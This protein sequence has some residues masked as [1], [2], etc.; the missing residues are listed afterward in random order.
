[1][2]QIPDQRISENKKRT[3]VT[4]Y[5]ENADAIIDLCINSN[6]KAFTNACMKA[7]N[8]EVD[9]SDYAHVMATYMEAG[10]SSDIEK[11]IDVNR[12]GKLRDV[13]ILTPIKEKYMGEFIN[14]YHNYQ[15]YSL[16]PDV[17]FRRNNEIG[18]KVVDL[19][20]KKLQ[21]LLSSQDDQSQQINIGDFIKTEIENWKDETVAKEQS[22]LEMLNTVIDAKRKY[23]DA[24]FYWWACEEVYTYR[25]LVGK[26]VQFEIVDPREYYRVDS[27]N[28]FVEDD[29]YGMRRSSISM[30]ELISEFYNNME[31]GLTES[32]FNFLRAY[33]KSASKST[34]VTTAMFLEHRD[35]F[36]QY[37]EKGSYPSGVTFS[38]DGYTTQKDHYVFTTEVKRGILKYI[39]PLGEEAEMDVD[40]DYTLDT[41][42][43]DVS[44]EW[45]WTS[46]KWEGWVFGGDSLKIYL[47]PRPVQLERELVS[48]VNICK[49][50]YNGISYIHAASKKKPVAYRIKDYIVLYKIYTLLEE[51]WLNKYKSWLTVPETI[52]SDTDDMSVEDRL[53]QADID[54]IF[55]F[56]DAAMQANPNAMNMLKE[57]ATQSVIS[58]VQVLNQVKQSIKADAWEL[59]NMNDARFGS[60][61]QYKGKGVTE[62]DY[63]QAIKGT[64]WSLEMFNSFRERDY[65]ANLDFSRAAWIDGKQGSF[66]D[67]NTK[68][69]KYV[70][71]DGLSH[72]GANI[73]IYIANSAELNAQAEALKQLA[74]SMG[75]NDDPA[76]AAE[77]VTN[78]NIG[79]LKEI[80][81]EASKAKKEFELQIS[82]AKENIK[83]QTEQL[84]VQDNQA[85]RDHDM[86]INT[87]NNVA[88]YEEKILESE[89]LIS[90]NE[91]KLEVD[92][93]ANGYIDKNEAGGNLENIASR[94]MAKSIL[95]RRK[96]GLNELK[97]GIALK[98]ANKPKT[99]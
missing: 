47:P 21:Q 95:E 16:D 3:D 43:G 23:I 11:N 22:A 63:N 90:I 15:V 9:R 54:S 25:R 78:K 41:S 53:Q 31:D 96:Q 89:T 44:I 39:S 98:N 35:A 65:M 48:N 51:R 67:P 12:L 1:M 61:S 2:I 37:L 8:G 19:M 46:Q 70:D 76:I 75:Q 7:A 66:V 94:D 74:F 72:L 57:V 85:Q 14:S 81:K 55:P 97:A 26:D 56:N 17:I 69:I 77:A 71:V 93:N 73:G 52:L 36:P 68:E 62:Y 92:Q 40:E 99:K 10:E 29:H 50:P 58:Y 88:S 33:I 60:T 80:I 28:Y 4:W 34:N 6:D 59:A 91:A 13:D 79:K 38:K 42:N 83:A 86:Q 32:Q 24:Y 18:S 87:D 30:E 64:V 84:R 82:T 45:V 27:G 20:F 5:K 49:S